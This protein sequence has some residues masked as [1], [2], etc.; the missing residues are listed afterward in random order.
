MT[1]RQTE[2]C[3]FYIK[4]NSAI[5]AAL[6]AGYSKASAENNVA[7]LLAHPAVSA[8]IYQLR[9]QE[10]MNGERLGRAIARL[11]HT[12]NTSPD[13][14]AVNL[15]VGRLIQLSSRHT[16]APAQ[17]KDFKSV[18]DPDTLNPTSN[19]DQVLEKEQ[20][21]L[22]IQTI[23]P[24]PPIVAPKKDPST[25]K[26]LELEDKTNHSQEPDTFQ[27][28]YHGTPLNHPKQ[29]AEPPAALLPPFSPNYRP[30]SNPDQH[31]T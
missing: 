28:V 22:A 2:F 24:A 23:P 16:F 20:N 11:D 12:I 27:I 4:F 13:D 3:R 25:A 30:D 17:S 10:I 19:Q 8:F 1:F 21:H 26:I 29:S 7:R 18:I 31:P 5:T 9:N 6:R 14:H 15:A